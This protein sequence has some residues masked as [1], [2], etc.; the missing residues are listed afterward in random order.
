MIDWESGHVDVDGLRLHYTRTGSGGG[1]PPLVLAHG[2][3]DDGPCWTSVA[4]ALAPGYDVVMADARGHGRSEAPDI[5]HEYGH[6][7]QAAD[8]IGLIAALDLTRPILLGHSMGAVT[9]LAVAG[10]APDLPAALLVEDPPPTLL[11]TGPNAGQDA[12]HRAGMRSW[13]VAI[14]RQTRDELLAGARAQ[15]PAWSE[16]EIQP[17]ADAK[18]R[19]APSVVSL[20]DADPAT[21]L[22]WPRLLG[23]IVCPALLITADPARGAIATPAD[24]AHLQSLIPTLRHVHI[25][26]AGHNIRRDQRESYLAAVRGFLATVPPPTPGAT[27]G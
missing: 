19:M 13:L 26:D 9:T 6:A 17:W 3:S 24:A 7:A 11:A 23:R 2:I 5:D 22:D 4:E 14:K 16:A 1:K 15:T 25:P 18:A 21:A 10:L 20:L 8:L 27:S 12:G